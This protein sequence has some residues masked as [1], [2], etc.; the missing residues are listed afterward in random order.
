M[1]FW[2]QDPEGCSQSQQGRN[3][4]RA[5]TKRTSESDGS[6]EELGPDAGIPST[7]VGDLVNVGSGGLADGGER[8]DG[9]DALGE[10]RVGGLGK[11]SAVSAPRSSLHSNS[12][13]AQAWKAPNSRVQSRCSDPSGPSWRRRSRARR[14]RPAPRKCQDFR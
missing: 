3:R 7:G 11:H 6:L 13:G 4:R 9:R 1:S 8:V 12:T 2:K 14:G 5:G 10:Q